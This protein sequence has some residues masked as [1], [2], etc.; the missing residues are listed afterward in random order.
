[1]A[2]ASLSQQGDTM[3][4][5]GKSNSSVLIEMPL[6]AAPEADSYE[7]QKLNRGIVSVEAKLGKDAAIA[8]VR[9]RNGLRDANA[10]LNSGRPVWTNA[11]A[12]RWMMEQIER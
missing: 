4:N 5:N 11:D 12:L 3:A 2:T 1:M 10:K 8:F 6:G 7:R 9:V